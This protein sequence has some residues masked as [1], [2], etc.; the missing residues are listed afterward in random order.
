[1][2]LFDKLLEQLLQ[3]YASLKNESKL[4]P[5]GTMVG[6]NRKRLLCLRVAVATDDR[7]ARARSGSPIKGAAV[8]PS[9]S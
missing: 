2:H 8:C 6:V 1:M 5:G 7:S 4:C 9:V 3:S